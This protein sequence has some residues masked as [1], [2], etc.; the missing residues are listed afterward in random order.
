MGEQVY[1]AL[2]ELLLPLHLYRSASLLQQGCQFRK[3]VHVR[4]KEER[5]GKDGWLQRVVPSYRLQAPANKGHRT[6]AIQGGQFAHGVQDNDCS[7]SEINH[8]AI[9]TLGT[10][11][12]PAVM[13]L[14]VTHHGFDP[15][16]M[17]WGQHEEEVR[18]V[19]V[20]PT[21]DGQQ[22]A[23]FALMRTAGDQQTSA[24][25]QRSKRMHMVGLSS[26]EQ[27]PINIRVAS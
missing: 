3:V 17:A 1:Q 20:Q 2:V 13:S 25:N 15:F 5:F 22:H 23:F 18:V 16:Q 14:H 26:R 7:A 21:V 12:R 11:Y 19:H 27:G 10:A 24:Y 4:T 8:L 9:F 6:Q